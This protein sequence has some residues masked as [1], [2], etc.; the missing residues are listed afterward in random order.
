GVGGW[1]KSFTEPIAIVT[2][3]NILEVFIKPLSL[4]MR[5]FGNVLGAFVIMELL[6]LLVPVALPV[7]FSFYFDVFDVLIQA[8]VFV[9]LTSMYIKEAIE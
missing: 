2:P 8:Y 7:P 3:I 9:F 4:C 5:L 6:K 1:I